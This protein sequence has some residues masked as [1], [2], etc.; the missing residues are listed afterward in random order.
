MAATEITPPSHSTG[1]HRPGP[2]SKRS[3]CVG[4]SA[5]LSSSATAHCSGSTR[6]GGCSMRFC[7]MAPVVMQASATSAHSTPAVETLAWRRLSATTSARPASASSRPA[8]R[9]SGKRRSCSTSVAMG[10]TPSTV[11]SAPGVRPWSMAR[12]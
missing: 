5:R 6:S 1:T 9:P 8:S 4:S 10:C 3:G 12:K 2:G 7:A 11:A